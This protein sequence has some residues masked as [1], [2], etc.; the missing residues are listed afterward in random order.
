[1]TIMEK[2]REVL[3]AHGVRHVMAIMVLLAMTYRGWGYRRALQEA[4][5]FKGI[6]PEVAHSS[7]CYWMLNA[8]V[9]TPA[10]VWFAELVKE[11]EWDED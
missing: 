10:P 7:I 3:A 6:P 5:A 8:G 9:E 1:M 4:A 11:V 2:C